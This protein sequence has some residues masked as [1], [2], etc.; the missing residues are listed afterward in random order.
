MTVG[1]RFFGSLQ[2]LPTRHF[3]SAMD[4]R[5]LRRPELE[6]IERAI[7]ETFAEENLVLY[8]PDGQRIDLASTQFCRRAERWY[9]R[10]DVDRRAAAGRRFRESRSGNV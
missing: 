1:N 5:H 3:R 8:G 2:D 7:A 10:D 4:K 9:R 6:A